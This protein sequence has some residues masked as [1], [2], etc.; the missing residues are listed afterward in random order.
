MNTYFEAAKVHK[1]KIL[2][3]YLDIHQGIQKRIGEFLGLTD[4]DLPSLRAIIPGDMKKYK[5]DIKPQHLTVD[6]IGKFADDVI[7]GN[8]DQYLKSEPVP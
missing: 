8:I 5:T 3:S 4:A 2:F 7:A 6:S 1:G